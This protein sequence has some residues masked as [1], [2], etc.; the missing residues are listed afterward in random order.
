[1]TLRTLRPVML[2]WFFW[3]VIL[4]GF[5]NFA[6]LRYAPSRPD[7]SLMWTENET[8]RNS[9]DGKIYLL[10][11]F[12]NTQVAWDSEYY[13]SIATVGYDDPA[14]RTL[15]ANQGG[16]SISYAFFPF[17]PMAMKVIRL[18]F[19]LFG[20]TEIGSSVAAGLAISLLGTLVGMIALYDIVREHLGEEGGLRTAFYLL[21]FPTSMFLATV[22][23]EG[24][25]IALA[26][27][28]LALMRRR[29]LVAAAILAA[30]AT[31]TRAVGGALLLP[32]LLSW[33]MVY[34]QANLKTPILWRLP[35]MF[36]PVAAY[37]LWRLAYGV[38]FEAVESQY[39]G[40]GLLDIDRTIEAW[41]QILERAREVPETATV[42]AMGMISIAL[43]VFSCLSQLRRYPELA[44]FGI[45]ALA[46]PLLGGWTG[47]QS[48]FRYVIVVPT[49]W[50]MLGSWG[51][52]RVFDRV[53]TLLCVLL[54]AMVAFLFAFD[55][56]VA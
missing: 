48:A 26:F 54:L 49:L 25:F 42:V 14:M 2:V 28:S 43:A 31:W 55:Y 23:T 45:A 35:V 56:W 11:P 19:T 53:W 52:S 33:F 30:L 47:T 17:Y 39:F 21:I 15:Q 16:H 7:N 3:A 8:R 9:N 32:L 6:S 12:M 27:G 22:Y 50:T 13:L 20:M 18:P 40:N 38:Q 10:E 24:L 5:M 41:T 29:Y 36:L 1:M 51:R 4:I 44:L 34:R 37:I 46:I